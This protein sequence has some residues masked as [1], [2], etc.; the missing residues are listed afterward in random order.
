MSKSMAL[1]RKGVLL[2]A[3][4][5]MLANAAAPIVGFVDTWVIGNFEGK[6]ALAGIGL[7]AVVFG[8]FYWGFGFLRMSTAGLSAQAA[9]AEDQSAVQAH[10]FRAVPMGFAIG[11]LL[12]LLQFLLVP[13]ILQFFPAESSVAQG[14]HTYVSARLYGLPA[15][16]SSIALMGWFIGLARPKRALYMQIVLNLINAPLSILFVVHFGWGI[17]GVGIASAIAEWCGLL[18]G[19]VLA[20]QEIKSRGGFDRLAAKL[21]NLLDMAALKK[22]GTAN[23]NI[24]IRTIALTLGFTFFARAATA[25]GTTFLAGH[26]V[27]MQFIT[28]IALVLDSFAHVAEA[29]VGA[30]YGAKDERRFN[31]A[32]RLTTEFSFVFAVLCGLAVYFLG[33]FIIDMI[34]DSEDV[35]QSARTYLPYCALAPVVGFGAWQL[36]G[37]FIGITRTAAMRNAGVAAVLIY[38]PAHYML[39]PKFGGAG[40]WSAFLIYYVVRGA[41][42]LPAWSAIKRDLRAA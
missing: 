10:L 27:L 2:G 18:A 41:T 13:L 5:I 39:E 36:D 25:Q 12:L 30:A 6:E 23:S 19:L 24:F 21:S 16:L 1:T 14:A 4:P 17:F 9:G 20:A 33:P 26:T 8:L 32:V 35:R 42:M 31:K 37:I 28:M 11:T 40:V 22:L 38:L 7:G 29:H 34:T 15:T 3:L